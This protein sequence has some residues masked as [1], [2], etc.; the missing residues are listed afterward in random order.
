MEA[1]E[2]S[3][4]INIE[5]TSARAGLRTN[6]INQPSGEDREDTGCPVAPVCVRE[7]IQ[8]VAKA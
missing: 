5:R 2:C 6:G 3:D 7:H 1:F 8:G 4:V